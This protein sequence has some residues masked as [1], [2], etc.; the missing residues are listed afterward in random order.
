M[1]GLAFLVSLIMSM[2]AKSSRYISSVR[3]IMQGCYSLDI[4]YPKLEAIGEAPT[5]GT[6]LLSFSQ[7]TDSSISTD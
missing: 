2:I 6:L 3:S 5:I 7:L 1:D 4:V